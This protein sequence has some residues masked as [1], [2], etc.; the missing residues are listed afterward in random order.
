LKSKNK[1][2]S[3]NFIDYYLGVAKQKEAA[4]PGFPLQSFLI[5]LPP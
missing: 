3:Y 2:F 4:L 1:H 5:W